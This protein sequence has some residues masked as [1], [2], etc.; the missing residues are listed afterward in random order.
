LLWWRR[1]TFWRNFLFLG[2][3]FSGWGLIH[4]FLKMKSVKSFFKWVWKLFSHEK[5]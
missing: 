4:F 2:G 3:S 1:K 5:N